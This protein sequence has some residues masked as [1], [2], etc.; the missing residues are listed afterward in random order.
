MTEGNWNFRTAA[1]Q[2]DVA[3]DI[4]LYPNPARDRATVSLDLQTDADVQLSLYDLSGRRVMHDT[5]SL[6]AGTQHIK[7]DLGVLPRSLYIL[8]LDGEGIQYQ[9]KLQVE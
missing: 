3:T 4:S 2:V 5:Y 1:P 6:A 9:E 8:K 7:L